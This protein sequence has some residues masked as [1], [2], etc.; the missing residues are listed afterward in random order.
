[1]FVLLFAWLFD[2][3]H[4]HAPDLFRTPG[5]KGCIAMS[6]AKVKRCGLNT[7]V[8]VFNVIRTTAVS[9]PHFFVL[10][11]LLVLFIF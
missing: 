9:S 8:G 1:V 4:T 3:S 6:A 5:F 11:V 2:P 7:F 10:L